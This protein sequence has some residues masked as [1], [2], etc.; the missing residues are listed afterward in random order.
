MVR[1]MVKN[2]N[3]FSLFGEVGKCVNSSVSITLKNEEGFFIRPFRYSEEDKAVIRK[4]INKMLKQGILVRSPATQVSPVLLVKKRVPDGTMKYRIV[5]DF[6][7]LNGKL[8]KP[9]YAQHLIQDA[10]NKIG[11]MCSEIRLPE[12]CN[13]L[14]LE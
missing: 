3:A 10:I 5:V 13:H 9:I 14:L 2:R 6:H 7:Q 11:Q 12:I 1:V 8:L 4:E